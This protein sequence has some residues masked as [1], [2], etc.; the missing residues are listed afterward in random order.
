[1]CGE[2]GRTLFFLVSLWFNF[3]SLKFDGR[4]SL[5]SPYPPMPDTPPSSTVSKM[6]LS[7]EQKEQAWTAWWAARPLYSDDGSQ[8]AWE[9]E[10]AVLREKKN[11]WYHT[12]REHYWT[13]EDK[14][15]QWQSYWEEAHGEGSEPFDGHEKR[16]WWRQTFGEEYVPKLKP[17]PTIQLSSGH[18]GS[19]RA[20][21]E[22]LAAGGGSRAAAPEGRGL[23]PNPVLFGCSS[24]SLLFAQRLGCDQHARL[25]HRF[26]AQEAKVL[27]HPQAT[28]LELKACLFA[29]LPWQ[30]RAMLSPTVSSSDMDLCYTTKR[31]VLRE[32]E[33]VKEQCESLSAW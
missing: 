13:R 5:R 14:E 31:L 15:E 28:E 32:Q 17:K 19:I 4:G 12:Y 25:V 11:W 33:T 26:Q 21:A 23:I 8:S 7:M 2:E 29:N 24:C 22:G 30:D 20:Q 18:L 3:F 6:A 1:M 16:A 9:K 27:F 10:R